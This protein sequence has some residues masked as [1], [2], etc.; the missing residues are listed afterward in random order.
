M[1]LPVSSA[2]MRASS[3]TRAS[4]ASAIFCSRRPRS[5]GGTLLQA[6]NAVPAALTARST[7]SAVP[8]GMLAM[9]CRL[10]GLSTVISPP[11]ALP[12]QLPSISICTLFA[13]P[14]TVAAFRAIAMGR[15]LL[16]GRIV[17]QGFAAA[18]SPRRAD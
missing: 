12:V 13:V 4:M 14:A 15:F 8:R 2:T 10:P 18:Y 6:G 7:S 11:E 16:F 1:A 17:G 3:S 5:R 9:T